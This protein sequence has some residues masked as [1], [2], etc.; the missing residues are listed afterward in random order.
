MRKNIVILLILLI[1]VSFYSLLNRCAQA[2]GEENTP[3]FELTI[4]PTNATTWLEWRPEYKSNAPFFISLKGTTPSGKS[5]SFNQVTFICHLGKPSKWEGVCMNFDGVEKGDE[6]GDGVED[7]DIDTADS[8]DLF[9]RG[10]DN[11]SGSGQTFEVTDPKIVPG[12]KRNVSEQHVE[13]GLGLRV[14]G[15]K[16]TGATVS[17]RANDRAAVGILKVHASFNYEDPVSGSRTPTGTKNAEI[18]I[19]LDNNGNDIADGWEDDHIHDY[20][21]WDDKENG[22]GINMHTGDALTVFEE[23]RGFMVQ[24]EPKSTKPTEKDVFIFSEF[25]NE[26]I[27]YTESALPPGLKARQILK[28]ELFLPPNEETWRPIDGFYS[29]DKLMSVNHQTCTDRHYGDLLQVV[30]QRS[31]WVVDAPSE[32]FGGFGRTQPTNGKISAPHETDYIVINKELIKSMNA[33]VTA[34]KS[35]HN[36]EWPRGTPDTPSGRRSDTKLT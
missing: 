20:N 16:M 32:S 36:V 15:T 4:K 27:A 23:Y 17:V 3:T 19:P 8:Y 5:I 31:L 12:E 6:D 1:I 24:G 28:H 25:P 14:S 34:K 10:D 21:P 7:E 13:T 30:K 11:P 2:N 22:P 9:F 26:G 18:S 29:D 35:S 33:Q